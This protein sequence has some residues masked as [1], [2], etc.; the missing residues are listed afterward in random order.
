MTR[1]L[2][3]RP[4]NTKVRAMRIILGVTTRSQVEEFCPTASI[5]CRWNPDL[6]MEDEKDIRWVVA[7]NGLDSEPAEMEQDG[8][9]LVRLGSGRY[10]FRSDVEFHAEYEPDE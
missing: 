10:E 7:S 5:G 4:R 8:D 1:V 9:W 2:D 3:F 6:D